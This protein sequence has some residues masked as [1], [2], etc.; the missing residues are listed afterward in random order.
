MEK[1]YEGVVVSLGKPT[2]LPR[3]AKSHALSV[4]L[5]PGASISRSHAH[6][7]SFSTILTLHT[8]VQTMQGVASMGN[9]CGVWF[10]RG[11]N[12]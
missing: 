8:T 11:F 7:S 6:L 9:L 5:K 12:E 4:I 1:L 3:H 10:R 2:D